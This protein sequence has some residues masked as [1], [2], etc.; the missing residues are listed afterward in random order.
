MEKSGFF[1]VEY[2]LGPKVLARTFVR[3]TET[4]TVGDVVESHMPT[5]AGGETETESERSL[6]ISSVTGSGTGPTSVKTTLDLSMPVPYLEE[7]GVRN[8][9]V[10]LVVS[11]GDQ[12]VSKC[13][14]S[15]SAFD[16]LM[17]V[18]RKYDKLPEAR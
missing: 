17:S 6:C 8:I 2:A 18:Q 12:Q 11:G 16:V 1:R 4:Q 5:D 3:A 9:D 15:K 7:F 13:S 14:G 10:H